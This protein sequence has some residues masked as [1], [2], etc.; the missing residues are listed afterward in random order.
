M[1]QSRE[2]DEPFRRALLETIPCAILMG[3]AEGRIIFWNSAAEELTGYQADEM[4]GSTCEVLQVRLSAR[5]KPRDLKTLCPFAGGSDGWDEECELRRKDGGVVSVVRKIRAVKDEQG[6]RIGGIQAMVNITAIKEAHTEIRALR[7]QISRSQRFGRIVGS[8]PQMR[9]LYE[10]VEMIAQTDASVVVE[11]ETGTGKE[12]VARTIHERGPRAKELFL[13]VNCGALPELLLEAELFGHIRGAFTGAS[14]D[15]PGRFEEANGGTLFLDEVT[16]MPASAQVKLLRA[17][18]EGEI[19]RVGESLPRKVDVRIIAASNRDLEAEVQ[20]GHFRQDL[21][22]RLRVLALRVPPLRERR[23]DIPELVA[24]FVERF[25]ARYKRQVE[26]CTREAM[27][28]LEVAD[29][30]GNVRQLEHAVEHAFVVTPA[31]DRWIAPESLPPDIAR[32]KPHPQ[33]PVRTS[34]AEGVD[35]KALVSEALAQA[36]GNKSAAARALGITR[37]G[38]YMKLRRLGL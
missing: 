8:S 21:F 3:D 12:V 4:I 11:G 7:R 14:A 25:N 6:E 32:S 1:S 30:P 35:E 23:D 20:A 9:R 29:W 13:A 28:L 22:Y 34:R 17:V 38:L 19:T 2:L 15:R 5:P 36:N 31:G 10:A 27:A 26:G 16:E 24:H 33:A 37:A 18:Q